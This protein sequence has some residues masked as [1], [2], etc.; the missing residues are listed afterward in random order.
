[1]SEVALQPIHWHS[2]ESC[3]LNGNRLHLV[4]KHRSRSVGIDQGQII[5][6]IATEYG[7]ER[8]FRT[9]TILRWRTDVEG[10]IADGATLNTPVVGRL[11][12]CT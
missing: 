1:M 5:S 11:W 9:L 6:C 8:E 4:V 12:R 10:I 7:I 2:A 3:P